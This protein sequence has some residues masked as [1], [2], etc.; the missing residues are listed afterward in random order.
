MPRATKGLSRSQPRT[1]GTAGAERPE[2]AGQVKEGIGL[3]GTPL[4]RSAGGLN[5]GKGLA[6]KSAER[7]RE[8]ATEWP[9]VKAIV[10]ARDNGQCQAKWL[11]PEVACSQRLDPHHRH[12]TGAGGPRLDPDNVLTL[13]SAHHFWVHQ[14]DPIRARLLGLLV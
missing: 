14:E 1:V 11:V 6:V 5:R 8:D 12:P 10:W 4:S 3:A 2:S 13:C 9:A 7:K